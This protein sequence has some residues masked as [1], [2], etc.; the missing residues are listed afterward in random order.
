MS[1]VKELS[2]NEWI[3][4]IKK[5]NDKHYSDEKKLFLKRNGK[6][7]KENKEWINKKIYGLV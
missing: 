2:F 1:V 3:A 4:E 5:N 7:I 6:N